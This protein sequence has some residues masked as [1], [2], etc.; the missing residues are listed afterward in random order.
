MTAAR[1]VPGDAV[2]VSEASEAD[3]EIDHTGRPGRDSPLCRDADGIA[4]DV[5][6]A[7]DR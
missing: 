2:V 3:T 7:L 4:R 5:L 1:A 6:A